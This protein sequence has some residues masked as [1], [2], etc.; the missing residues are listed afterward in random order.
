MATS[1]QIREGAKVTT[2]KGS[3]LS[4]S[5]TGTVV[6]TTT[7]KWGKAA[8]VRKYSGQIVRCL[9]NNLVVGAKPK[10]APKTA[11]KKA[12]PKKKAHR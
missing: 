6:G 7:T 3:R 5:F 12:A 11:P 9:V 1:N 10:A 4:G 2:L 8:M